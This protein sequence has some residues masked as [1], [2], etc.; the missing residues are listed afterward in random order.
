MKTI[1][2]GDLFFK[3]YISEEE[4]NKRVKEL[5]EIILKEYDNQPPVLICVLNGSFVFGADLARAI[6]APAEVYFIKLSSYDGLQST[7]II[8]EELPLK[9]D[10]EGKNL[11]II[12]DIIETGNTLYHLQQKLLKENCKSCKI[13]SLLVKNDILKDRVKVDYVGFEIENDF[14]VGYGMDYNNKGRNLK[15]IY[16]IVKT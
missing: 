4:I 8:T 6:N 7:G 11:L 16:T 12:E 10:V 2:I 9:I 13:V 3:T 1:Q 14:V 5:G 15:S